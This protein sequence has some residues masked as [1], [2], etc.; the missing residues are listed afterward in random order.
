MQ[1]SQPCY[2]RDGHPIIPSA[3]VCQ[4]DF[5]V[6]LP[7]IDVARCLVLL[8]SDLVR[9]NNHNVVSVPVIFAGDLSP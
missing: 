9:F 2:D 1:C 5:Q 8:T 7:E 6:V 3:D 4:L